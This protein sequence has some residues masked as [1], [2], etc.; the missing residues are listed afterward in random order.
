MTR[1][2]R[3]LFVE[4]NRDGTVGGSHHSL[5]LL[6]TGLDRSRF[7]PVVAFYERHALIDEFKRQAEVVL[8]P[9][10]RPRRMT[11][12]IGATWR[13]PIGIVALAWQKAFNVTR[14]A[15]ARAAGVVRV[16][17]GIRPDLIHMNN[18]TRAGLDWLLASRL[19]GARWVAHQRGFA[20]PPFYAG[21][22]DRVICISR[23]VEAE[24]LRSAPGLAR[25]SVQIYNG[26][27]VQASRRRAEAKSVEDVRREFGVRPGEWLI[28][29]VGNIQRWKGQDVLLR[30]LPLLSADRRWRCVV[31]GGVS[32]DASSPAYRECLGR[33]VCDAGLQE[34]V[35]FTGYR[36]DV[37]A[38]VNACDVLVHTSVKPEPMGRVILEAM[39][40][41]KPVVATAHGGPI[42]II[43]DGRSGLL[44][45]PDDPPALAGCLDRLMTSPDLRTQIQQAAAQRAATSFSAAEYA[46]RVQDVYVT[47]WPELRLADWS[48]SS[49]VCRHPQHAG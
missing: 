35:I 22:F 15:A 1:R 36:P 33:L 6:V 24:L 16:V 48:A 30:A 27:D 28:G 17:A 49:D 42:E 23:H 13:D 8:L 34:R 21:L 5:L 20:R 26:V 37:P 31:V 4:E 43:E 7:E 11:R 47:L 12:A 44:V 32:T 46:R 10:V 9:D 25:Q 18:S 14:H 45:P 38:I 2:K 41:G 29:A 19:S 39:A 3:I 40:L